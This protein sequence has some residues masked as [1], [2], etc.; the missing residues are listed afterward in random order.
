MRYIRYS[1]TSLNHFS[2]FPKEERVPHVFCVIFFIPLPFVLP[3]PA[4]L[5][6]RTM[7]SRP[8]SPAPVAIGGQWRT[9]LTY[10]HSGSKP[11]RL[12]ETG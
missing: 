10:M 8:S 5:R 7:F 3:E 6:G 11:W 4:A 1:V 12:Y 2:R 9:G